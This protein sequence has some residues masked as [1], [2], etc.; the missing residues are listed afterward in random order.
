VRVSFDTN[1]R[2]ALWPLARARAV[3]T[4]AIRLADICLPSR[5]DAVALFR[6]DEP[7]AIVDRCLALG[8]GI[9]ALKLGARGAVVADA[10]NR[11]AL[12]AFPCR[13]VD[14]TGA[15]D[16]FGGA[17]VARLVAGDDLAAA[18][19]YAACA[20]ELSTEGCGAVAPIPAADAVQRAL[21]AAA[22]PSAR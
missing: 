10:A 8:A 2:P 9:V 16:T 22:R 11:H 18:G 14:A 1:H 12:P 20:A 19:R 5:D 7:D 21:A 15:G 4:E 13:P 17:F 6:R 3:M